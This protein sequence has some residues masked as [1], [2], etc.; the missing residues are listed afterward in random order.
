MVVAGLLLGACAAAPPTSSSETAPTETSATVAPPDRTPAP[1]SAPDTIDTPGAAS[2]TPDP[3]PATTAATPQVAAATTVPTT[4]TTV[5]PAPCERPLS[6]TEKLA[7]LVWPSVYSSDWSTARATVSEHQLGGVLLMKPAGWDADTLRQRLGEL[8]RESTNGLIVATD[9]EGGDVQRL[10][11][12]WPL[13]SQFDVSTT[14]SPAEAGQLIAAHAANVADVGIDVVLGPVV[15]VLPSQGAPPLQRS[16]FF[17]GSPDDVSDYAAAYVGAWQQAGIEPVLK[18][19]PGHGDASGDT[20]VGEGITAPLAELEQR[21]LVPYRALAAGGAGVMVGHLE[22]PGLT[23]D[24]PASRSGSAI[25]YL[26]DQL[27]YGD[28]LI[29]SDSLDMDA[30]GV[31]VPQAAVESVRAGV[32]VVLFTDPTITADVIDALESA[33]GSGSLPPERVDAAASKVWRLLGHSTPLC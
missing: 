6:M 30:V 5:A 22:T 17:A 19:F 32:D 2:P 21:D 18:H 29:V 25:D 1:A 31:P 12:L 20:H 10:G 27:G 8:E 15:D 3:P 16:R 24:A 26:R 9:E 33:V 13:A 23:G 7:L 14:M 11:G 28:A 4:V